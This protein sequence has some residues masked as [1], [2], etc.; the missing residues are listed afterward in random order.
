MGEVVNLNEYRKRRQREVAKACA[1]ENR[2]RHGRS[3]VERTKAALQAERRKAEF[4]G[5]RLERDPAAGGGEAETPAAG[6]GE[7][8]P[9]DPGATG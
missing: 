8:G 6:A 3:R 5:K 4:D 9:D 1:A 7:L 2:T